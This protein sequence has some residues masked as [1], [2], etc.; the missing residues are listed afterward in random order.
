MQTKKSTNVNVIIA[1]L[2]FSGFVSVFNETILNVA[3]STLMVEMNV[4]AGTVQWLITAYMIIVAVLVPVTAFLIQTFE[5]KQLYLSAMTI[6]LIG[7]ICA[8]CSGSFI[9]LLISRVLQAVGTGMLIPIMMNTV[10]VVTPPQKRGSVMGLCGGALVLGPA[11]GPT[12]AGIVL[13]FFSWHAL[14][15]ILIPIIILAMILGSIYLVNVSIVTR[16]KIDFIS[17]ML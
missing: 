15:I 11:L 14:F 8:A 6:F 16:P 7:T 3:L 4:T 2:V 1:V 13:Q 17:I 9:M 12:V 5:T 10:L